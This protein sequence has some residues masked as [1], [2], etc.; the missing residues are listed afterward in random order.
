MIITI[1]DGIDE[2]GSGMTSTRAG[3][4]DRVEGGKTYNVTFYEEDLQKCED[5]AKERGT[6]KAGEIRRAVQAYV[7][8]GG[9]TYDDGVRATLAALAATTAQKKAT[10]LARVSAI[11]GVKQ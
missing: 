11:M 3:R 1:G 2:W 9:Q 7:A 5:L 8:S 6:S 4:P 10:I